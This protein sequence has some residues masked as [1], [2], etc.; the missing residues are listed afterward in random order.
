MRARGRASLCG[1]GSST[2]AWW[3]LLSSR[4]HGGAG[5]VC[6][7][8]QLGLLRRHAKLCGG[9]RRLRASV[10]CGTAEG[11]CGWG[12]SPEHATVLG[13]V[14]AIGP[15][16]MQVEGVGLHLTKLKVK[17]LGEELSMRGAPKTERKRALQLRLRALIITAAAAVAGEECERRRRAKIDHIWCH[18]AVMLIYLKFAVAGRNLTTF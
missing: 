5:A 6:A 13:Y 18:F 17:Q 2:A 16:A 8:A 1:C 14:W 15:S 4:S 12:A 11:V 7:A 3:P 9:R 10:L